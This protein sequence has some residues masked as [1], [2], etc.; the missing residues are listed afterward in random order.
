LSE[1]IVRARAFY[2][3]AHLAEALDNIEHMRD[4]AH[5]SFILCQEGKDRLDLAI[6]RYYMGFAFFRISDYDNALP[7]LEQ[8]LVEFR[9]LQEPYWE[10]LCQLRI[11]RARWSGGDQ[12][13]LEV[14]THEIELARKTGERWLLA[15]ALEQ[16]FIYAWQ[17][18][19]L[20]EANAYIE[21][22]DRLNGEVGY[23]ISLS[24]LH[25]M[26]A[27]ARKDYRRARELYSEA[28]GTMELMGEKST[29]AAALEYLG[30]LAKEEGNL[31]EAQTYVK[32]AVAISREIG[33]NQAIVYRLGLLGQ[34]HFLQ[35]NL[36]EAKRDFI[37][38]LRIGKS[39]HLRVVAI[40][41]LYICTYLAGLAPRL[42]IQ[43]LSAIHSYEAKSKS[44]VARD[45]FAKDDFEETLEQARQALSESSFQAAWAEGEQL[46]IDEVL[47]LALKTLDQV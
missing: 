29:K 32:Q 12:I 25:G 35:G 11:S 37:E 3:D 33:M 43:I 26:I 16:V 42:A 5:A 34:I 18:N 39:F 22:A 30:L 24:H 10:A 6:A 36:E 9:E 2:Q 45:P 1:K 8:S 44:V 41:F 46:S 4:S 47:D 23:K 31:T 19:R 40:S 28:I 38:S 14:I 15:L 17:N 21:E 13:Y 27:H 7:L 20:E